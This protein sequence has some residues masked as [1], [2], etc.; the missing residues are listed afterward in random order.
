MNCFIVVA[1]AA[2]TCSAAHATEY[3]IVPDPTLTPEL[4]SA[5]L[6]PPTYARTGPASFVI[7]PVNA[8]MRSW[9]NMACR[10]VAIP[11]MRSTT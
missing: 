10:A 7:R 9:P 3:T 1:L 5:P 6:T 11:T 8:A 4:P 2:L